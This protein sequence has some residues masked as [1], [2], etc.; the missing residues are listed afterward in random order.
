MKTI[1]LI[2]TLVSTTAFAQGD[3]VAVKGVV[4][5]RI[6]FNSP[7][8]KVN[9]RDFL[10][11]D[12]EGE[13]LVSNFRIKYNHQL[14]WSDKVFENTYQ[15]LPIEEVMK[16]A[17]E[18]KRL[19]NIPSAKEVVEKGVEMNTIIAKLLEKIE[20]LTI[21]TANQATELDNLKRKISA[22]EEQSCK[23]Q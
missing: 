12:S 15:L 2:L 6:A 20:E 23:K 21:Y 7:S 11:L 17:K 4:N 5:M 16:F 18:N 13:F 8:L 1:F 9:D 19:P 22:L 10:G 14:D 3:E